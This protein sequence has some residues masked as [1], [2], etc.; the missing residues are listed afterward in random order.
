MIELQVDGVLY[1]GW[2][3]VS[4]SRSI[5]SVAGGFS[6]G[7]SQNVEDAIAL[8]IKP[9]QSCKIM[10]NKHILIDGFIDDLTI[11]VDADMH[12][13]EV[14]GR[15]KTGDLVDCTV[16]SKP[17]EWRN[18]KIVQLVEELLKPYGIKVIDEA[19]NEKPI[20]VFKTEPSES[21]FQALDRACKL[22]GVLPIQACGGLVLAYTGT[23]KA[24]TP[25]V[26]GGNILSAT[27]EYD[28]S[29]RYSEY[30]VKGQQAKAGGAGSKPFAVVKDE[31]ITRHRP[32]S[33]QADGQVSIEQAKRQA[34]WEKATREAKSSK[35]NL[36]VAGWTTET[37]KLWDINQLV[38]VEA[39]LLGV[40]GELLIESVE[41]AL[42]DG[43]E[44]CK[45]SLISAN[46]LLIEPKTEKA[47]KEQKPTGKTA[48]RQGKSAKLK[49]GGNGVADGMNAGSQKAKELKRNADGSYTVGVWQE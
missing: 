16:Q 48:K 28:Y 6:L 12:T 46:A 1:S 2:K 37:G 32:L 40:Q 41:Y 5:S 7:V 29:E 33:K 42:D 11:D 23:Q 10:I 8:P 19:K 22:V 49:R 38:Q 18:I 26:L 39:P 3:T 9:H 21:V 13:I 17:S 47:D 43:G 31:K 30:I 20:E 45:L 27:A 35:L 4:V 34:E 44:I 14:G 25:L 36:T 15:D 24:G